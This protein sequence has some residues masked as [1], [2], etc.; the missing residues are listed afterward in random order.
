MPSVKD[1]LQTILAGLAIMSAVSAAIAWLILTWL[2]WRHIPERVEALEVGLQSS[3][4][5]LSTAIVDLRNSIA[6]TRNH[7]VEFNGPPLVSSDPVE[8]GGTKTFIYFLRRRIDCETRV[9]VRFYDH[10]RNRYASQV[11]NIPARRA[12]VSS[13]FSLFSIPVQ[14]P[15]DLPPGEYSYAPTIHPLDCGV[16]V[17]Q[18]VPPSMPFTVTRAPS[19]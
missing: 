10:V 12:A 16:Y 18:A 3:L 4:L 14:I 7:V 19:P 2:D 8:A 13:E 6:D 9:E 5:E 1:S 11:Y 15:R 17:S